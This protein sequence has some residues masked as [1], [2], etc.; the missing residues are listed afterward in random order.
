MANA[1]VVEQMIRDRGSKYTKGVDT[2][3]KK[4]TRKRLAKD[5]DYKELIPGTPEWMTCWRE[6]NHD[7]EYQKKMVKYQE[8]YIKERQKVLEKR[9]RLDGKTETE[10]QR[11]RTNKKREEELRMQQEFIKKHGVQK[12]RASGA[13]QVYD[14]DGEEID[15]DDEPTPRTKKAK[16]ATKEVHVKKTEKKVEKTKKTHKKEVMRTVGQPFGAEGRTFDLYAIGIPD[17]VKSVKQLIAWLEEE[18]RTIIELKDDELRA[19]APER[20]TSSGR[21]AKVTVKKQG[22]RHLVTYRSNKNSRT[23]DD[24]NE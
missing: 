3:S 4:T 5:E 14:E 7:A 8:E 18:G 6:H 20:V 16:K 24:E 23:V 15:D 22:S 19:Y 21:V 2:M 10:I 12:R 1:K 13:G 9:K 11:E 17:H